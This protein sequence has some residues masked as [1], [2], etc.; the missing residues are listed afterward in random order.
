MFFYSTEQKKDLLVQSMA[1]PP[2][3]A[4][5]LEDIRYTLRSTVRT[6]CCNGQ[7]MHRACMQRHLLSNP[8]PSCPL[9]RAEIDPPR[10]YELLQGV[11]EHI[12]LETVT[13][14]I[15]GAIERAAQQRL[16]LRREQELFN[17]GF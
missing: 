6:H 9:C 7:L 1:E 10:T 8:S 16:E 5:C 15:R 14:R 12:V 3:C 11:P 2:T 4:I 17:Q 13:Q